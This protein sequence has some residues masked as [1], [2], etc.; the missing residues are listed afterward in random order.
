MRRRSTPGAQPSLG[1]DHR[2]SGM[3]RTVQVAAPR[4]APRAPP[5]GRGGSQNRRLVSQPVGMAPLRVESGSVRG[6]LRAVG[7]RTFPSEAYLRRRSRRDASSRGRPHAGHPQ[8]PGLLRRRIR[9]PDRP[10]GPL[11]PT[12]RSPRTGSP[13][14]GSPRAGPPR[15][16]PPRS[17]RFGRHLSHPRSGRGGGPRRPARCRRTGRRPGSLPARSRRLPEA[18]PTAPG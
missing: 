2:R 7:P 9:C 12:P 3:V 16:G 11:T 10:A 13:R 1:L 17:R 8:H 4:F 5:F 6:P 14:A 18:R 15:A